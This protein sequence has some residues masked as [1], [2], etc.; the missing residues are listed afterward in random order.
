MVHPAQSIEVCNPIRREC[1]AVATIV[2]SIDIISS[3]SPTIA[4]TN[5]R[6][7][8]G[9][10]PR[11]LKK[12]SAVRTTC[13]ATMLRLISVGW[14]L[15]TPAP[16]RARYGRVARPRALCSP[17][18]TRRQLTRARPFQVESTVLYLIFAGVCSLGSSPRAYFSENRCPLFRII[19]QPSFSLQ[20][21][22]LWLR[23]HALARRLCPIRK[24]L[25]AQLRLAGH[26][27]RRISRLGAE[28]FG[29]MPRP[30]RIPH[31]AAR[32]ANHVGFARC[33]DVLGLAVAGDQDDRH[34]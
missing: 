30:A 8:G 7:M 19:L 21:L 25:R 17:S 31:R 16:M 27:L 1:N 20:Q 29:G 23:G 3:A 24:Q 32:Q 22:R 10:S 6:R 26:H 15:E 14:R 9:L 11:T 28:L 12:P 33:H 13:W 5:P 18:V 4:K 34:G 2:E